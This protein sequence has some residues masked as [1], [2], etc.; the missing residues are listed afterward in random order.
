MH[1]PVPARHRLT[2]VPRLSRTEPPVRSHS[3]IGPAWPR[4]SSPPARCRRGRLKPTRG[5][6][7]TTRRRHHDSEEG[8]GGTGTDETVAITKAPSTGR[9]ALQQI[10]RK[11]HGPGSTPSKRQARAKKGA[12]KFC[13]HISTQSYAYSTGLWSGGWSYP[14]SELSTG[15][16]TPTLAPSVRNNASKKI[17]KLG[18]RK[19]IAS[20]TG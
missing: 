3:R 12:A 17:R 2:V 15:R 18:R 9:T 16:R 6:T 10:R 8:P 7:V 5:P 14:L 11:L 20:I 4:A 13:L 19:L 1:M